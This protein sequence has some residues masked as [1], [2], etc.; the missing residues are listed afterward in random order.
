MLALGTLAPRGSCLHTALIDNA[1]NKLYV[2]NL[3]DCRVVAGWYDARTG[4][5]RCEV[6]SQIG[7]HAAKNPLEEARSVQTCPP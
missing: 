5:W 7:G 6:M 2:A 1:T 4:L 3:G